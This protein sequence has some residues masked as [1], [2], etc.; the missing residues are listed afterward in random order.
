MQ[1]RDI[2]TGL[3]AFFPWGFLKVGILLVILIY[4]VF[5]ALVVR[6]ETLM[7]RVVVG[8]PPFSPLLKIVARAHFVAVVGIFF[9]ALFL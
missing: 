9:L 7:S 2:F 8:T 4:I 3:L 6:Q 5:A 1:M